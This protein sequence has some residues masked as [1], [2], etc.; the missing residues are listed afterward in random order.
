[1]VIIHGKGRGILRRAI[2]D[3]LKKDSRVNDIHP[4]EPARGGDGFAIVE[5]K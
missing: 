2:Y 5:L 1:M 3:M 4:G